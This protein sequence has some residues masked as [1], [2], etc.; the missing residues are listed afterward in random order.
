MQ[1]D[2]I[3]L[4]RF[5]RAK[6]TRLR[7]RNTVMSQYVCWLNELK[8]CDQAFGVHNSLQLI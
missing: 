1:T 7:K 3:Y 6:G 5:G 8:D 2:G 4:G